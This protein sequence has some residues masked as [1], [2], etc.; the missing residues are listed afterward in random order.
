MISRSLTAGSGPRRGAVLV[1]VV[2]S[3][4]V[5]VGMLALALDG[6]RLVDERRYAQGAADA[7]ALSAAESLYRNFAIDSGLDPRKVA[8]Q[9]ALDAAAA[10]GYTNDG[11]RSKVVVNVPPDS[12]PFAGQAGHAEVIVSSFPAP[13]FSAVLNG[14]KNLDVRAR[15]VARGRYRR[16]ALVLLQPTGSFAYNQVDFSNV[17][18]LGGASMYVNSSDPLAFSKTSAG[19]VTAATYEIAGGYRASG[20]VIGGFDTKVAP[21]PDPLANLPAPDPAEYPV[22]SNSRIVADTLTVAT[23][24][25]GIYRGGFDF[26]GVGVITFK[27]GVYIIDGGG[28]SV[29]GLV[30]L[31]APGVMIYNTGITQ[32]AGP[33]KMAA[34]GTAVWTPP[35]SGEY[36]G[37]NLFQDRSVDLP[38]EIEGLATMELLGTLYAPAAPVRIKGNGKASILSG[39]YVS[40]SIDISNLGILLIDPTNRPRS[41]DFGMVE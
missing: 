9:A 38:I 13:G 7:A 10:R 32:P 21:M 11:V 5:I 2:L 39:P 35:T 20:I 29:S 18:V 30:T 15:G 1:W 4:A 3:L 26:S 37:L 25:P 36:A 17:T 41:P 8:E 12:G 33:V 23:Y 28:L 24:Q 27:P 14:G 19:T 16:Y 22:R 34:L 6:G 31:V 40:S